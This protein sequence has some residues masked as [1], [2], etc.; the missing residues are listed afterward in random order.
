M[1]MTMPSLSRSFQSPDMRHSFL[2]HAAMILHRAGIGIVQQYN[3]KRGPCPSPRLQHWLVLPTALHP[4]PWCRNTLFFKAI[5]WF[6]DHQCSK[7]AESSKIVENDVFRQ[8]RCSKLTTNSFRIFSRSSCVWVWKLVTIVPW[9]WEICTGSCNYMILTSEIKWVPK[10]LFLLSFT[11]KGR[12]IQ[13]ALM[14]RIWLNLWGI[15]K[16]WLC[17]QRF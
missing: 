9:I 17:V 1:T 4:Q 14:H 15:N 12:T 5:H 7:L 3:E 16:E 8:F 6:H 11:L 2:Y 13:C 10:V